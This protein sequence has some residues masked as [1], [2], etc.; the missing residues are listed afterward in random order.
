MQTVRPI[1]RSVRARKTPP[2][3]DDDLGFF[4]G[5]DEA[6]VEGLKN[7]RHELAREDMVAGF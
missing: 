3:H 1:L 4:V 7:Y 5:G 6:I 2:G